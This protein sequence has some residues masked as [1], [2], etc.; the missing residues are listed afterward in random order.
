MNLALVERAHKAIRAFDYFYV[1]QD[2]IGQLRDILS[3]VDSQGGLSVSQYCG[4]D[5]SYEDGYSE[6]Y[7]DV[8]VDGYQPS[9]F[10]AR[11][12]I[13]EVDS[14]DEAQ[15]IRSVTRGGTSKAWNLSGWYEL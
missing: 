8:W 9:I 2:V 6:I 5:W 12:I 3:K 10:V 7:E 15:A 14:W 1:N 13:D 4:Q 11:S